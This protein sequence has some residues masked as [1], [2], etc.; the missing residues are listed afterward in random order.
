MGAPTAAKDAVKQR[1][2][3]LSLRPVIEWIAIAKPCPRR[4]GGGQET[5]ATH[6]HA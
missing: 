4:C 2:S 3:L 1:P 5:T 6:R